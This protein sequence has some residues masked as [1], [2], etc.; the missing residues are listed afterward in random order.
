MIT[1][2][3]CVAVS[4]TLL[5][6]MPTMQKQ[7]LVNGLP[8]NSMLFFTNLTISIACV[9]LILVKRLTFKANKAQIV[10]C[11]LMGVFGQMLTGFLLNS[12]Y[13][14]LPVGTTTMLN[15]LYPTIV[16]LIMGIVFREGFTKLQACATALSILGMVFLTGA[17]GDMSVIGVVL[18]IASA[19]SY[20]GYLIANEKG[21]ANKLPIEIKLFYIM[22]SAT[23]IYFIMA[24]GTKTFEIP[25][26]GISEWVMLVMGSGMFSAAGFFLMMYGISRLGVTQASFVSMLEPIISVVFATIWFRDSV[27]I[28]I[29]VGGIMV[30]LSIL[31]IAINGQRI[32]NAEA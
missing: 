5:G 11:I 22:L 16:G 13:L 29:V 19:F 30:M 32:E 2:F 7:L 18:A 12:S 23:I 31:L 14:Y 24:L 4:A 20:S 27:T 3:I 21:E 10:Q 1:G 6:I 25:S 9:I 28:G 17:G 26:G 8:I 15:F